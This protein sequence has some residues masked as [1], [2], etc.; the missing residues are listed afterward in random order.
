[1]VQNSIG[2]RQLKHKFGVQKVM[3]QPTGKPIYIPPFAGVRLVECWD[4]FELVF[5]PEM[6]ILYGYG[7]IKASQAPTDFDDPNAEPMS[8][9]WDD[10]APDTEIWC[11]MRWYEFQDGHR[12]NTNSVFIRPDLT[13]DEVK[14]RLEQLKRFYNISPDEARELLQVYEAK[15]EDYDFVDA[16]WPKYQSKPD[17]NKTDEH[18]VYN[19]RLKVLSELSPK[20]IELLQIVDA[21]TDQANRKYVEREMV[22]SYF[23]ELAHYFTED[24]ILAWQKNNPVGTGWM[25]EFAEVMGKPRRT[26]SPVN[27][28]LALN[29]LHAKYNEMTEKQLSI[30]IF[31]RLWI[32]LTPSAIKKRRERLGLTSKRPTGPPPKSDGQ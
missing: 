31:K 16:T 18:D 6:K 28:E 17:P 1:L 20:T 15:E 9:V 2:Q 29:W 11:V 19:A 27:Y 10:L 8:S 24:E 21:I 30:S 14:E 22:Q 32:W 12:E 26:I 23:A 13:E 7:K 3:S 4:H 25:C 5:V